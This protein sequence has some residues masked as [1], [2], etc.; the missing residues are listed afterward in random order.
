[1]TA[2]AKENVL[3]IRL[4]NKLKNLINTIK[5][6]NRLFNITSNYMLEF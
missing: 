3:Y 2:K 4:Q 5:L 6:A 1:M